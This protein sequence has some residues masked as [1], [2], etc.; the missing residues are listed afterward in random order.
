MRAPSG[1]GQHVNNGDLGG[2]TKV[3]RVKS[4]LVGEI[5]D[6]RLRSGERIPSERD[7]ARR[8]GV[9]L[10]TV[11]RALRDLSE[12]GIVSREHGRGTFVSDGAA[13]AG[14]EFMRFRDD[15]GRELPLY[16]K[17]LGKRRI[18]G[19]G[20]WSSF[21]GPAEPLVRLDRWIN[22]GGRFGLFSEFFLKHEA[23]EQLGPGAP[24]ALHPNLR[25]LLVQRL[26]LS[27]LQVEETVRFERLPERAARRL[28]QPPE[29]AGI[30][31]E[32]R[33]RTLDGGALF[34]Q[35]V[36]AATF[37]GTSLVVSR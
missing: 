27:A 19:R 4:I 14:V 13:A 25:E 7:L 35:R 22:V 28:E 31:I 8:L 21:F 6:G 16:V 17:V 11:Q 2:H 29:R 3:D 5:S 37:A 12:R 33:G 34:Y 30:I 36:F 10:G 23:F 18:G 32:L 24:E 9:S 26:A 15:D 20:P 1:F